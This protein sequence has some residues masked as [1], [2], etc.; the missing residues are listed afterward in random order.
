L[1]F[2]GPFINTSPLGAEIMLRVAG[3]VFATDAF[4]NGADPTHP[5][6]PMQECMNWW[7]KKHKEPFVSDA[8]M[9]WDGGWAMVQAMQKAQSV[10]PLKVFETFETMTNPGDVQTCFGPA[11]MGGMNRFGVNRVLVR[12]IPMSRFTDGKVYPEKYILPRMGEE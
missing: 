9:A 8:F 1:G 6:E 3:P 4:C 12:P 5:T 7:A 10:D 11:R 2:K